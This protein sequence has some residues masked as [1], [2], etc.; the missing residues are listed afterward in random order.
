VGRFVKQPWEFCNLA[1]PNYVGR[2]RRATS[3][4]YTRVIGADTCWVR[5]LGESE[6]KGQGV[7]GA[8]VQTCVTGACIGGE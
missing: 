3:H 6:S 4:A 1:Q 2:D 8:Y 7:S 5:V